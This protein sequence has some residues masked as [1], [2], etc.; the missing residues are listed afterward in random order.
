MNSRHNP[1]Q[2]QVAVETDTYV[3][4]SHF[5]LLAFGSMLMHRQGPYSGTYPEHRKD[6]SDSL[7][8]LH[9]TKVVPYSSQAKLTA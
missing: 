3:Q 8:D 9:E 4:V 2:I 5:V 1:T 6:E 7:S